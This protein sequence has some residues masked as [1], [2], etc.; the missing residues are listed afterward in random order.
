MFSS[1]KRQLIYLLERCASLHLAEHKKSNSFAS[2]SKVDR[3]SEWRFFS[4]EK[5]IQIFYYLVDNFVYIL[6]LDVKRIVSA[7]ILNK[8]RTTG[9][10]K[11]LAD[12]TYRGLNPLEGKS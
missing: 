7:S 10:I 8:S 11:H 9:I 6:T 5:T 2:L 12:A 3:K 1:I 4:F